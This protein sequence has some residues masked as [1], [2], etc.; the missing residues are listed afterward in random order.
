MIA[1]MEEKVYGNQ[2]QDND[3]VVVNCYFHDYLL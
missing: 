1:I 2:P 3:P